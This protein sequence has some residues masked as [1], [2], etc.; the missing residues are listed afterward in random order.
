MSRL[1]RELTLQGRFDEMDPVLSEIFAEYERRGIDLADPKALMH[2]PDAPFNVATILYCLGMREV[3]GR[4]DRRRGIAY[5]DA[6]GAWYAAAR[7]T[8]SIGGVENASAA[9]VAEVAADQA[10]S[11]RIALDP[12]GEHDR[13]MA[14]ADHDALSPSHRQM[15]FAELVSRGD[16]ARAAVH[17]D[18]VAEAAGAWDETASG[19]DVATR[20][21]AGIHFVLG[22]F[23]LNH[24]GNRLAARRW[25]GRSADLASLDRASE[26]IR[27][28]AVI[29][30]HR[31][32]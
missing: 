26:D 23:A 9:V 28:A 24:A 11:A 18:L 1:L 5:F 2:P 13:G 19:I 29:A 30:L 25:L 7:A 32:G 27:Y 4:Q 15:L 12:E 3:I 8:L 17:H 31:A 10:M 20:H 22:I 21:R 14:G 16:M 6:A